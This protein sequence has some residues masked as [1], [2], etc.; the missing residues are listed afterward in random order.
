MPSRQYEFHKLEEAMEINR[1][2]YGM[3]SEL[4]VFISND[5]G[6]KNA[7]FKIKD[8]DTVRDIMKQYDT[9]FKHMAVEWFKMIEE[10]KDAR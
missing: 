3:L 8:K 6:G 10:T 2:R 9:Q 7:T 5:V 4:L 1:N